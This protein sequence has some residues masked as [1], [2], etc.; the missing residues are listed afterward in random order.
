MRSIAFFLGFE[1]QYVLWFSGSW[2]KSTRPDI[3]V[4]THSLSQGHR[5]CSTKETSLFWLFCSIR[6][7]FGTTLGFFCLLQA[8]LHRSL[9]RSPLLVTVSVSFALRSSGGVW[10]S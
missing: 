8:T 2:F 5:D 6:R 9:V 1:L 7:W 4:G 10:I 3:R